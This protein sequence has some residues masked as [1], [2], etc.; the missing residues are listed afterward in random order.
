M[1]FGLCNAPA[2]FQH[3]MNLVVAGLEGYAVHLDDVVVFSDTWDDH[4]D[5]LVL[6]SA[7]WLRRISLSTWRSVSLPGRW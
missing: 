3:L 7:A 6:C 2:T 4:I 5:E 1:S